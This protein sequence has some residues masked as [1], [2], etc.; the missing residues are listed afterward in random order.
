M[1]FDCEKHGLQSAV[2]VSVDLLTAGRLTAAGIYRI[3][4][5]DE[6]AVIGIM[7]VSPTVAAEN[8][9]ADG[10]MIQLEPS[11]MLPVWAESIMR[12]VCAKCFEERTGIAC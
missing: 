1:M 3:G 10:S 5:V 12:I 8:G 4:V 9:I 11:S 6:D 2:M 7:F